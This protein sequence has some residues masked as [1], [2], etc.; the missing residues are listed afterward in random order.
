MTPLLTAVTRMDHLIQAVLNLS[1]LGRQE[2]HIE[3]IVTEALVHET[4]RPLARQIAQRQ[5]QVTVGPVPVVQADRLALAQLFGN[6]LANAVAYLEPSRP[7]AIAITA[8][9]HPG[10]TVFAVRDNGRG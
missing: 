5:V 7:G 8:V 6:L 2:L 10:V 9:Q 1:R 4:L 3:P